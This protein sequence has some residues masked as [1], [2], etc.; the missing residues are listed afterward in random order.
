MPSRS[1]RLPAQ[2]RRYFKK[3]YSQVNEDSD[4]KH[5]AVLVFWEMP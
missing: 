3:Q 2:T 4:I 5:M 1:L